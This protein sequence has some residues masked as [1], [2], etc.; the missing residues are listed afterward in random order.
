MKEKI[1][2]KDDK[3]KEYLNLETI[4]CL[5]VMACPILDMVSFIFRNIF[6]TNFSPSTIVRPIIAIIVIVAIFFKR[7][8]KIKLLVAGFLYGIYAILHLWIFTKLQ[9]DSAYSNVVHETQ[10]I[11]NYSFMILNLFLYLYVFHDKDTKKLKKSLLVASIIY[12]VSIYVSI[13][14][15]T[16]S[17]TYIEGMGYK[18]WFESGNSISAILILSLFVILPMLKNKENKKLILLTVAL[19]GIFLMML[20]GTRVGLL[21]F[22]LVVGLYI[23][24]EAFFSFIKKR[25][26]N[27][28]ML[29]GGVLGMILVAI[30]IGTVGSAT[31]QRRKHLKEIEGNIVDQSTNQVA[32]IS[33]DLLEIKDQIDQGLIKEEYMSKA[34]QQSILDLYR[35]ANEKQIAN[36]DMRMQQLIYNAYL[37][38]NQA[39]PISI[40]LGNGYMNQF[41]ELVLEMEIPA[42]LFNFGIIGFLLYFVP[43]LGVFLYNF[44]FGI[45]Y[46]R[47]VDSEYIM[48]LAGSGFTF[49]LSFFSG[50]VFFSSSTMM[51]NIV[52]NALLVNR[53]RKLKIEEEQKE[54]E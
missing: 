45:K 39:N 30:L 38:K 40:L 51:V 3:K 36:N 52:M 44:Y 19:I 24:V 5:Y 21:G 28:K 46:W 54:T 25:K 35:V 43:F 53:V 32:H 8:I 27:K 12:I 29:I 26:W 23:I 31:I 49:V 16:S 47:K 6:E 34:A 50:Y 48:L 10:Y 4:L 37:V 9:T 42:F 2:N 17:S 18:G 11:I 14:T 15:Q 7:H 1:I 13:F 33:G 20:V 41:R 22:I